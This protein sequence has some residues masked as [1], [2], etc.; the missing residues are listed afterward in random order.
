MKSLVTI[1]KDGNNITIKI[2]KF[3]PNIDFKDSDFV[4]D[5]AANPDVEVV[6]M[7]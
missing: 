3:E 7:R 6:D 4:F 2:K 5:Q 1:G